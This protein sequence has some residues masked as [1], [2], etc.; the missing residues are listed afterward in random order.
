MGEETSLHTLSAGGAPLVGDWALSGR[1]LDRM[2]LRWQDFLC[3]KFPCST[4]DCL[5][6]LYAE[7]IEWDGAVAESIRLLLEGRRVNLAKLRDE[8]TIRGLIDDL[9][10]RDPCDELHSLE[11]YYEALLVL[12]DDS[13]RLAVR[14]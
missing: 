5:D 6:E 9:K 11:A 8:R 7:L 3:V 1:D 2:R 10:A 13:M 14:H 12:I 4:R